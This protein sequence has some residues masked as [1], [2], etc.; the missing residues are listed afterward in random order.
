[1]GEYRQIRLDN[2][3][4]I[5]TEQNNA[6]ETASLQVYLNTGSIYETDEEAGILHFV[7]HMIFKGTPNR[8][9]EQVSSEMD[10]LGGRFNAYTNKE[11]ICVYG[12]FMKQDL[13]R[14]ADV[15][16][17]V[18]LN[19]IF[20][21]TEFETEKGVI[22]E[23]IMMGEDDPSTK[24]WYEFDDNIWRESSFGRRI[25][26]TSE[27][28][29]KFTRDDLSKIFDRFLN[30]LNL[31]IIC[32]GNFDEEWLEGEIEKRFGD[33]ENKEF[34]VFR[35]K[36]EKPTYHY[37]RVFVEKD[38][39][40]IQFILGTERAYFPKDFDFDY[41]AMMSV[42]GSGW[43]SKLFERIREE[44][45][46]VYGIWASTINIQD[47]SIALI[48]GSTSK[49]KIVNAIQEI[50]GVLSNTINGQVD[51][52]DLAKAKQIIKSSLLFSLESPVQRGGR[53]YTEF[54]R[55]SRNFP[56]DK[57][58]ERIDEVDRDQILESVKNV[59][60]DEKLAITFVGK[61]GSVP[62]TEWDEKR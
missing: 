37:D 40:Q 21:K 45:G 58:L 41:R 9:R 18:I 62:E 34:N 33:L 47:S 2:G 22:L 27:N 49:E 16:F 28:I 57:T 50:K 60:G 56:I 48:G 6:L 19:P 31:V 39:E 42:L 43:S 3:L 20:P 32:T 1:M 12:S 44:L 25:I 30:P 38:I 59:F 61:N 55:Y 11:E 52:D 8:T 51:D 17:D 35:P 13:Q 29:K 15:L 23:E 14:T 26:G 46:Y 5:I 7:E 36:L 4:V 10:F 24:V 53:L 54:M